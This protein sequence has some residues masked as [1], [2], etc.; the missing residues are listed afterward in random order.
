MRCLVV[1]QEQRWAIL[2]ALTNK[3]QN[4]NQ[5][6]HILQVEPRNRRNSSIY[7]PS[8]RLHLLSLF[9][10]YFTHR[11]HQELSRHH[12]TCTKQRFSFQNTA[13]NLHIFALSLWASFCYMQLYHNANASDVDSILSH[14]NGTKGQ[15]QRKGEG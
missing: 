11:Q 7:I 14:T 10:P 13:D 3:M 4:M 5:K 1:V 8:S 6:Y 2:C 15:L 9:L 12:V